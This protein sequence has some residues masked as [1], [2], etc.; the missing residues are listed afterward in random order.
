MSTQNSRIT[1]LLLVE[2]SPYDAELTLSALRKHNIANNLHHV[3][4]GVEAID[5][6]FARGNWTSRANMPL[7]S[8]VLLDLK[9]PRMNGMEVLQ[10]IRTEERTKTLPVVVLTSSNEDPDIMK[11]Y[12]L[13]VNSYIVK[14][15]DFN[16][17][18]RVVK[19]IGLYWLLLNTPP[20]K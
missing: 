10:Y 1:D 2:D 13:G 15:V 17:F 5:F 14:P 3:E 6:L 9:M 20:N 11:C 16:D 8:V 18:F 12:E 19:D 7:P 4:D